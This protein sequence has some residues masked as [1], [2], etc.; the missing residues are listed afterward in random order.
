MLRAAEHC[1]RLPREVKDCPS[2]ET[3]RT[4]LDVFLCLLL[5]VTLACQRFGQG[6]LQRPFPTLTILWFCVCRRHTCLLFLL[7][8]FE[9]VWPYFL[10]CCASFFI[11]GSISEYLWISDLPISLYWDMIGIIWSSSCTYS[12]LYKN[13]QN[14][15]IFR[16]FGRSCTLALLFVLMS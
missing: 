3:V 14:G 5:Q 9:I 6:D 7:L 8:W 1:H 16:I 15:S 13:S 2:P 12:F 11:F 10:L 4:P